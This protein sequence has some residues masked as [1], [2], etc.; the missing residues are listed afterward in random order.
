MFRQA[1]QNRIFQ[2]IIFQI[3][4]AILQGKLKAGDKLPPE[5]EL[6]ETFRTSRGTLREAFRVLEQK[7][8]IAIKT[9]MNGGAIVQSITTQHVSE[10]LALLIRSQRI[11]LQDLAEFREGVEGLVAGLATERA[12]TEDILHLNELLSEARTHLNEGLSHWDEFIQTDNELHMA[13]AHMARNPVYESVLHMVHDNINRYYNRFLAKEREIMEENYR[14]LCSIVKAVEEGRSEDARALV[15]D[16]VE[17]FNRLMKM[18][19]VEIP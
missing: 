17:R 9:G 19:D 6:K 1:K 14:D 11:P 7:G 2:D 15:Q 8:L 18:K 16:H 4:E 13:M 12:Q 10:S 5:R 3:E